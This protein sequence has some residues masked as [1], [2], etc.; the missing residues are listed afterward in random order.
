MTT[1]FTGLALL[2]LGAA[3]YFAGLMRDV[4]V[5]IAAKCVERG[6]NAARAPYELFCTLD[7]SMNHHHP[8]H[9]QRG[10][11]ILPVPPSG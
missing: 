5:V 11:G 3:A 8:H 7:E 1:L 6:T 9:H 2:T 10:S 4:C